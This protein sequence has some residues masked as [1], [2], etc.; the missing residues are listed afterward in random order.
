MTQDCHFPLKKPARGREF[1]PSRKTMSPMTEIMEK[2]WKKNRELTWAKRVEVKPVTETIENSP[3]LRILSSIP[4]CSLTMELANGRPNVGR[5]IPVSAPVAKRNVLLVS[6][7]PS[8]AE[9]ASAAIAAKYPIPKATART[10]GSL[11]LRNLPRAKRRRT[12]KKR[13]A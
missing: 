2:T 7:Q 1:I 9:K 6:L 8:S 11:V 3:E 13:P 12:V 4:T 10:G 5:A